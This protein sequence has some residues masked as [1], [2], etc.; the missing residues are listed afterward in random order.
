MAFNATKLVQRYHVARI[1]K[2]L[3]TQDIS[4]SQALDHSIEEAFS[5]GP[6][7]PEQFKGSLRQLLNTGNRETWSLKGWASN[8]KRR[9]IIKGAVPSP[10]TLPVQGCCIACI[11]AFPLPCYN[12]LLTSGESK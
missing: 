9:W 11:E 1:N 10:L 6:L 5:R 4:A 7:W 8:Y 12:R 2:L 3:G